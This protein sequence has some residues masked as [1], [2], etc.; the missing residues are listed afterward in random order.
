M[1]SFRLFQSRVL[2]LYDR[3]TEEYALR[4]ID[5]TGS[6]PTQQKLVRRLVQSILKGYETN[7]RR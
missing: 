4:V 7:G 5:A 3:L 2:D 1:E 6:I